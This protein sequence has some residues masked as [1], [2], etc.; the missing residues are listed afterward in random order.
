MFSLDEDLRIE[1][2]VSRPGVEAL[3]PRIS[4]SNFCR[5]GVEFMSPEFSFPLPSM[6]TSL[7]RDLSASGFLSAG[8]LALFETSRSASLVG[9]FSSAVLDLLFVEEGGMA[10]S[11]SLLIKDLFSDAVKAFSDPPD[12][13]ILLRWRDFSRTSRSVLGISGLVTNSILLFWLLTIKDQCKT[14][15]QGVYQL[16][17]AVSCDLSPM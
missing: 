12:V 9:D 7:P 10:S 1:A 4:S 17:M 5:R 13:L 6:P 14:H 2:P 8:F 15:N 3:R 11:G 16:S